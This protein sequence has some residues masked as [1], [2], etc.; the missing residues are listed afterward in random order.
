VSAASSVAAKQRW[1]ACDAIAELLNCGKTHVHNK[2]Y[3]RIVSEQLLDNLLA[4]DADAIAAV[5][6]WPEFGEEQPRLYVQKE[7]AVTGLD[8]LKLAMWFIAKVG[9]VEKA[10]RAIDYAERIESELS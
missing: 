8:T 3:S 4:G 9:G 7:R 6:A 2:L 10:R 5:K 1:E